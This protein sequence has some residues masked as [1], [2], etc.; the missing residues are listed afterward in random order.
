MRRL[1]LAAALLLVVASATAAE[2]Y[3]FRNGV[4]S[5]GDSVAGLMQRAGAP[6]RTVQLENRYGAAVGER[7]EYYIDGKLVAFEISGGRVL[8]ITEAR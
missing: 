7:W 8:R 5:V 3:R 4:V 2:T 6:T 1:T